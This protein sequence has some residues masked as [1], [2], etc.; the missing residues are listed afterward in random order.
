MSNNNL[1]QG[2]T[3]NLKVIKE[4]CD[5][6]RFMVLTPEGTEYRIPKF[7]FQYDLQLPDEIL[8]YVKQLSPSL[9]LAQDI[10]A[11]IKNFY[12]YDNEY[13]FIVSGIKYENELQYDLKDNRGLCFKLINPTL[14]LAKND[15]V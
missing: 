6:K 7:R 11:H 13:E 12:E 14:T 8:C 4:K 15:R 1:V 10:S 9:V 3:Y 2:C 5:R